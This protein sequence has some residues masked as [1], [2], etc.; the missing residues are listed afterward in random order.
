[1]GGRVRLPACL[2]RARKLV[3]VTGKVWHNPTGRVRRGT[4]PRPKT[5]QQGAQPERR[6]GS[7]LLAMVL[8]RRRVTLVVGAVEFSVLSSATGFV[9]IVGQSRPRVTVCVS[10]FVISASFAIVPMGQSGRGCSQLS[11]SADARI[12]RDRVSCPSS[13]SDSGLI[14]RAPLRV[15]ASSLPVAAD[16]VIT[17]LR[18]WSH[19][20]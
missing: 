15:F 2:G 12:H 20:D 18:R 5:P 3:A 19:H 8:G 9:G 11:S 6:I 10:A 4:V 7:I 17:K 14:E 16:P 1:M 13:A